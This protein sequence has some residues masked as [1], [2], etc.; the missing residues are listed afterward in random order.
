MGPERV[1]FDG[2]LG[3]EPR[4]TVCVPLFNYQDA[5]LTA[6]ESAARQTL[7]AVEL[8]VV[9]DCSQDASVERALA[10]MRTHAERFTRCLLVQNPENSGGGN[11]ARNVCLAL[12]RAPF[13][14][15]LDADNEIYPR[16]L[17]RLWAALSESQAAMA[18][19]LLESFGEL[20]LVR[21]QDLWDESLLAWGV[22]PDMMSLLRRD[23]L[24]ALGGFPLVRQVAGDDF[25]L[26]CIMLERGYYGIQ[27]PEILGRYRVHFDSKT[28]R[29]SQEQIEQRDRDLHGRHPWI[30]FGM[31]K[32]GDGARIRDPRPGA[33]A[34]PGK[35]ALR[36]LWAWPAVVKAARA[37]GFAAYLA[38]KAGRKWSQGGSW[39]RAGDLPRM[40]RR[41][42]EEFRARIPATTGASV[43][44]GFRPDFPMARY[45]AW[46]AVNKWGP[47]QEDALRE[48]LKNAG[49]LP[50]VSVVTPVYRPQLSFF[51]QTAQSVSGQVLAQWEWCLADDAGGD[52]AVTAEL[53]RLAGGDP[54]VRFVTRKTRGQISLATNSAAELAQGEYLA[55]LDHDD[56][57]SPDCLA[58]IALHLKAH[59]EVD[60]LYSDDDKV[61]GKGRRYDPQFKPDWSPE[62]LLGQMYLSH[63]LVIRRSL[64]ESLGGLR[65]GLEG[66]Q[67]HDLAL[68]ASELAREVAHLPLV[69]YHWRAAPGSTALSGEA[70]PYS[71]KAGLKA[72]EDALQRRGLQAS[73]ERPLWAVRAQASLIRH[74]FPDE[75]PSVA[76][77]VPTRDRLD[78]LRPCLDSLKA[79][80]Y[81]NHQ[82]FV[83]DDRSEDAETRAYLDALGDRVLRDPR[84][85]DTFNFSALMNAAARQVQADFV[86]FLNNDTVVISPDW[87]NQLVGFGRLPGV[88]AVGGRL[89][90]PDGTVQHAGIL[91]G[92]NHGELALPF[93]GSYATDPGYLA[94]ARVCRN[95]GAVTAA[96]MLTPRALFLELGGFDEQDFAVSFN[97]AD[98]CFRLLEAGYRCVYAPEAELLHKEGATRGEGSSPRERAKFRER[99][100]SSA[101][102]YYNPNLSTDNER[103]EIRPRRLARKRPEA[104]RCWMLSHALDLTGAPICQFELTAA[105]RERG[106]LDPFVACPEDGPLRERYGL[107][108][109]EPRILGGSLDSFADMEAYDRFVEGLAREIKASGAQ[110]VYANTLKTFSAIDAAHRLGLPSVWNIRESEN[111]RTYYHY[112]P[113]AVARRALECFTLPYQVVFVSNASRNLHEPLNSR[114]NF[115]VIR[116]G[117]DLDRWERQLSSSPRETARKDLDLRPED[118]AVLLLGTV[119]ERKGQAD[120][121]R[122]LALMRPE[123]ADTL[124]CFIVGD[125]PGDYSRALRGLVEGLPG[126]LRGRTSVVPETRDVARYYRAADLFVCTSR[127]ESY[128]RV[129]L[130]AMASGLPVISTPVFGLTEQLLQGGNAVFYEPGDAAA[131][132]RA[133]EASVL[134]RGRLA[135]MGAESPWVLGGL[136]GFKEMVNAYGEIFRE[137]AECG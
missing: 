114:H 102:P 68:R 107:A 99:Y 3:G 5:I 73:V 59:P 118:L 52:A 1:L 76:V 9:D 100:A 8:V 27:V 44:G 47:K 117:L 46:L 37:F 108:G 2:G 24:E 83:V 79:T 16:C 90:F 136:T 135:A 92:F 122:A 28:R 61:D 32:A 93:R 53:E 54:R 91:R 20:T 49:P 39:P 65:V 72:V 62:A 137:A 94:S 110:V 130:E 113:P 85:R 36:R 19:P 14:F 10:W 132:A 55:F 95:Y 89:L 126:S 11:G 78:L 22:S 42:R 131:L 67:D 128:P 109:M 124:R 35:R 26:W 71:F 75:G 48:R 70:K 119:C 43:F 106:L 134:D 129:T 121:P 31:T 133:L 98:Y 56:L 30:K 115:R 82:V 64:F 25:E 29:L 66:S 51:S 57:L 12:A 97:D 21:G 6:L 58:E 13:L 7:A 80:L 50:L 38:R 23:S 87:L 40:L 86:V 63:L 34:G 88:G 69:L 60:L 104:P 81:R 123:L 18:F 125:R 84:P 41:A 127:V 4:V 120:L 77:L 103:F 15:A 105:L 112:L 74:R 17:E 111:W 33:A 116:D 101:E 45:D 96:C